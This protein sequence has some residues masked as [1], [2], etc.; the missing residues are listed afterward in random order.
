MYYV[1]YKMEGVFVDVP[2]SEIE[3]VLISL[4]KLHRERFS[5]FKCSL[6]VSLVDGNVIKF[7]LLVLRNSSL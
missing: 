4:F 5:L 2:A 7:Y 6:V 3:L 1:T